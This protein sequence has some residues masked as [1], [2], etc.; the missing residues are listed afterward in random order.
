MAES[1][2][3]ADGGRALRAGSFYGAIQGK[4]ELCGAI[5]TD[6]R[7]QSPRKLPSHS[8]ELPFFG[9]VMD[10]QYSERYGRHQTFFSPFTI[11]FRPAG[12]PHQD[13][14]G[15]RGVRFFE[16]ELRPSWQKRL[17]DCSGTLDRAYEDRAGGQ[18][19]W[20]GMKLYRELHSGATDELA[21]ESLLSDLLACIAWTPGERTGEGVRDCP[22]WL[23]RVIDKIAAE[24]TSR[25]TLDQLSGEAGVHPVHLSRVFRKWMGQGIG[26]YVHRLRIRAACEQMLQ[27]EMPIAG[28][29]LATGFADQSHFTRSFR[30]V[31]G[32]SPAR[33]R[34]MVVQQARSSHWTLQPAA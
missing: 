11:M 24:Y 28:I 5:F 27:S 21:T 23:G 30:R 20:L 15:P 31:T 6:L 13:E 4:R 22:R 17:L 12:V 16:I 2:H 18:T 9:L 7:H 29:G 34:S 32:M 26:E 14:I 1:R 8:H 3:T 10:G 25:L 33:F 19:L